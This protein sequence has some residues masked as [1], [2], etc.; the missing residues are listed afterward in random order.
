MTQ[1]FFHLLFVLGHRNSVVWCL[2]HSKYG[3][4]SVVS[5][6]GEIFCGWAMSDYWLSVSVHPFWYHRILDS[7][8]GVRHWFTN[9]LVWFHLRL[10]PI[11]TIGRVI[12]VVEMTAHNLNVDEPLCKCIVHFLHEEKC[13]EIHFDLENGAIFDIFKW[14]GG[15]LRAWFCFFISSYAFEVSKKHS[16]SPKNLKMPS[17][18]SARFWVNSWISQL[19]EAY[20]RCYFGEIISTAWYI[21]LILFHRLMMLT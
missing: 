20:D 10:R 18:D 13:F 8:D 9:V 3:K 7:T 16:A 5:L 19:L 12:I 15:G 14:R 4:L 1:Q 6:L 21:W 17:N 2:F 11:S